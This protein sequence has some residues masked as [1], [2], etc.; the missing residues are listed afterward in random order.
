MNRELI[1]KL[2][3]PELRDGSFSHPSGDAMV[4]FNINEV[5]IN[6]ETWQT[7]IYSSTPCAELIAATIV[8]T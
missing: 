5:D 3:N 7:V 2:R 4:N 1:E 8:F 6:A